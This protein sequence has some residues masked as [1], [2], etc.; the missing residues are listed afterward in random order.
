MNG[1]RL[2]CKRFKVHLR[3]LHPDLDSYTVLEIL[4]R[5]WF[6]FRPKYRQMY[7]DI[8][9]RVTKECQEIG[10]EESSADCAPSELSSTENADPS[11]FP[12]RFHMSRRSPQI[13]NYDSLTTKIDL[14]CKRRIFDYSSESDRE[15]NN[16][17]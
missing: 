1:R 8:A 17:N 3:E 16:N 13:P 6:K 9:E 14:S 7:N 2:F 5:E 10:S 11:E 15:N 12:S 4:G